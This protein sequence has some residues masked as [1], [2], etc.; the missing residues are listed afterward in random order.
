MGPGFEARALA[1]ELAG[2]PPNIGL[3][4]HDDA[5]HTIVSGSISLLAHGGIVAALA[6]SAWLAP[7]VVDELIPVQILKD[8]PGSNEEPAPAPRVLTPRRAIAKAATAAQIIPQN[9]AVARPSAQAISAQALQVAN[10]EATAAPTEI[11]RRQITSHRVL[12]QSAGAAS[13]SAFTVAQIP[14][15]GL[16][17]TDL[18]APVFDA[19][20]PRQIAPGQQVTVSAPQAFTGYQNVADI[21]YT[22][23]A[24]AVAATSDSAVA[25]TGF[26]IDSEIADALVAGRG[27]GGLGTA[28]GVA[29]CDESSYVHRYYKLIATRTQ[30][31]W[32]DDLPRGTPADAQVVLKFRLD[33]SGSPSHVEVH[34]APNAEIGES[35][36][37]AL[38]EAAPFPALDTNVRC[39][40]GRPLR[41]KFSVPTEGSARP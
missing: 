22:A 28:V 19:T 5:R 27:S 32:R 30:S 24:S 20:G 16:A 18:N 41:A 36:R 33:E 35:C 21:D 26:A 29:R 9:A 25:D 40:A 2:P 39:L 1:G 17:P 4:A 13:S 8:L 37:R 3:R 10:I 15:S 6:L 14:L 23:Q 7:D 38:L 34:S 31:L 12:A 11:V